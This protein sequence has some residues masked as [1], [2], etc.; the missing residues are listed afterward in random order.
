MTDRL[1][2]ACLDV[3][4]EEVRQ[5]VRQAAPDGF[6]VAFAESYDEAEQHELVAGADFVMAG[7]P[8]VPGRAIAAAP[9]LK[10]IQK[11]GVGYDKIDLD[12][13]RSRGIPVAITAGANAPAVA[14]HAVGLMLAVYRHIPRVDSAARRG[15]WLKGEM[16]AVSHLLLGKTVGILGFGHIGRAVARRLKGFGVSILCNDIREPRP[17]A[18]REL[19]A[20]HVGFDRLIEASDI[21]TIH[22]PLDATTRG[23]VG[24][25]AIARMRPGAVLINT[26]RGGVV[27]EVALAEAVESGRLYGAGL[28][29]FETE[30][31]P[32]DADLL[33][34]ERLVLT[35]HTGGVVFDIVDPVARHAFGNMQRVLAGEPLRAEDRVVG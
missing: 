19:G 9:R 28:D 33:R 29:V 2:V 23:L 16:R 4:P 30:P 26:A 17:E 10:L 22:V 15:V 24:R 27:D 14:E 20:S 34:L 7:W 5:V 3:W 6:E 32:A 35:P 21:L 1:R 11:W 13:A 18:L 8:A 12:A 31:L 25:D